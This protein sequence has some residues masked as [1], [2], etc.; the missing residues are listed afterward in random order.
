M[1][2]TE[3]RQ[4]FL[5]YFARHGHEIVPS[6][7]LIPHADPTLLFTNAGMVQFKNIFLGREQRATRRAVSSQKCIRAGGKHNDLENVGHTAR[8]HTLFEML[9][10]FSFGDYFKQE[11][12]R[13]AWQFLTAELQLDPARLFITVFEEDDEAY[14]IWR[15]EIGIPSSAIARI[16][17]KD[18]FWS[19]GKSGPCGPCSEIFFDHGAEIAGGAPGSPDEDGD[20]FIEIWNLVF[21]QYERDE[22]GTL[23]PLPN[24]SV[25]TGMGLERIAAVLQGKHN[26]YDIDLF[27][28][29]IE[30]A[31][32]IT[33]LKQGY[34]DS[35]LI[36]LRVVAD[37]LRAISFLLAEGVLPANEGR[38]FVLRRILR[39]ACRHGKLLGMHEPFI[40]RL[41]PTLVAVMGDHFQELRTQERSIAR[42]IHIEEERFIRTLDKGLK[43]VDEALHAAGDGGTIDGETLFT[44]YDT[45]GFPIDLTADIVRQHNITLDH[46]GFNACMERQRQRARAAW[47]GSGD[48]ALPDS[49]YH[50]REQCGASSFVGYQTLEAEGTVLAIVVDQTQ[51]DSLTEGRTA[52]VVTNQTPFY[53]ESGGQVGDSGTIKGRHGS[54]QVTDTQKLLSDLHIHTGRVTEGRIAVGDTVE[55]IV[56]R[57]RRAA[58]R[59]NHTATH[60]LQMA[61]K[62]LLGDHVKQAGS[63]VNAERLR[64][65]FNHFN[66]ITPEEITEIEER[67]YQDIIANHPVTTEIMTQEDAVASGAIA[68]FGEKYGDQVRVVR[69]GASVELCGGTHVER[70]GDIGIFRITSETGIAAGVRRVEAITGSV[71]FQSMQQQQRTLQ[72][73][74]LQLKTK[75]DKLIEQSKQLQNRLRTSEKELESIRARSATTVL[76]GLLTQV[77]TINGIKVVACEAP[78]EIN[79]LRDFMDKA[80]GKMGSAMIA[81]GC[82]RGEKVQLIVGVTDDLTQRFHAGK[83]VNQLAAIC[84]GRGGG[85]AEM[86]MAGG[87]NPDKLANALD[88]LKSLI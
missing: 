11:A 33:G 48:K 22:D 28:Q 12:I 44:L 85:K 23:T 54:F 52:M 43:L 53:G 13:L 69:A 42:M 30:A 4:K 31:V 65:D 38:G 62:Q 75:P 39:R 66:P 60:L 29:L 81:F 41:V 6:S 9:G 36:S 78:A 74:A 59:R 8:H 21:M 57:A 77:K 61:L 2:T 17:A 15:E 82:R 24:P 86:A 32:D 10:N 26:N 67:I 71:A 18:N 83:L 70:T 87:T 72:Q 88:H 64:F 1:K 16:G 5:D 73:L 46:D 7:S 51:V 49:I 20:R 25:D 27:Q 79:N 3:I 50:L 45:Y 80:K 84:D 63:Q 40:Y 47:S 37:H 34:S 19:M 76:D 68:L 14:R 55:Q 56:D 35:Q 58:I